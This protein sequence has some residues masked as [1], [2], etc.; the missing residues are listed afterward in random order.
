MK[1]VH[2]LQRQVTKSATTVRQ[3]Y[4]S[5]LAALDVKSKIQLA[6][7]KALEGEELH[8]H[9]LFQHFGFTSSPPNDTQCIVIPLGGKTAH[10]IIIATENGNF[11]LAVE[12]GE[13]CL[14][15]QWGAYVK[16]KKERICEID[17]DHLIINAKDDIKITTKDYT[18]DGETIRQTATTQ[19]GYQAPALAFEAPD[20]GIATATMNANI[21]Q[22]GQQ[23]STGDQ[24]AGGVSQ[25]DHVHK[26]AGGAGLSGPPA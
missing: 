20:G 13:T 14:Y 1:I 9:E 8:A 19:A 12:Q 6:R 7:M 15:N 5:R 26:D 23:T 24:I 18:V 25:I 16:L 4:R 2:A 21:Q 11:R 22:N 3:A 10:S 17:C